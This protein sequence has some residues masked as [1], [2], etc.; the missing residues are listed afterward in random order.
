MSSKIDKVYDR[1]RLIN[2]SE[3]SFLLYLKYNKFKILYIYGVR[4]KEYV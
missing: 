1:C 4:L 2:L 3:I